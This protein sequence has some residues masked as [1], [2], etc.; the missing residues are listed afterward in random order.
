MNI[1]C[2]FPEMSVCLQKGVVVF[3][4]HCFFS[5]E[6]EPRT[7]H[8]SLDSM[9]PASV[10]RNVR[11]IDSTSLGFQMRVF[12]GC[13]AVNVTEW[14]CY[15][16][17][18]IMTI[19]CHPKN[20]TFLLALPS[21]MA[22]FEISAYCCAPPGAEKNLRDDSPG[23]EYFLYICEVALKPEHPSLPFP[24]GAKACWVR[25]NLI[26]THQLSPVPFPFLLPKPKIL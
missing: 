20:W 3:L 15:F 14:I 7:L 22:L 10:V 13:P 9:S 8:M 24:D 12:P 23:E 1:T 19:F 2:L 16:M 6:D 5:R 17:K 18:I 25:M 21:L 26:C 4:V 11:R